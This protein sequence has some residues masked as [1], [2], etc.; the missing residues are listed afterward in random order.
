MQ[1]THAV[2]LFR[3]PAIGP[4]WR[5][6]ILS[7][8]VSGALSST[9]ALAQESTALRVSLCELMAHPDNYNHM[10]IIVQGAVSH[11]FENF[12]LGDPS[13]TDVKSAV[14]LTYGSGA[15]DDITYCCGR[16]G[17]EKGPVRIEGIEVVAV[18]DDN[19]KRFRK[20]LNSYRID[21][22]AKVNYLQSG[23]SYAVQATLRG[24]FFAGE[25]KSI[26]RGFGHLGC[27][28]LLAIEQ[29]V[30]IERVESNIKK[31]ERDCRNDIESVGPKTEKELIERNREIMS[32]NE[33]WR[34]KDFQKVA[35]ESIDA[36]LVASGTNRKD[37]RFLG[38]RQQHLTDD[39][40]K[41]DQY[42]NTCSWS[43]SGAISSDTYTVELMKQSELK[44]KTNSW[45]DIAWLPTLLTHSHCE[46]H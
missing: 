38:C 6:L 45:K 39:D 23:P 27:C 24:R 22:K 25:E 43:S 21:P 3:P 29:V 1:T 31:G 33:K 15:S 16:T 28:V 41:N 7:C 2:Q 5:Y 20:L 44:N 4:M 30:S 26:M 17:L 35:R 10:E 34:A 19:L 14:W 37:L 9:S 46:Q 42:L 32:S 40:K 36:F 8:I 11:E 13:C 18:Q 12:S